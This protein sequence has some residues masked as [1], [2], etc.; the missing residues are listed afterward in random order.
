MGVAVPIA[1]MMDVY[2]TNVAAL[3]NAMIKA[4]NVYNKFKGLPPVDP[5]P[6]NKKT[7]SLNAV[8]EQSKTD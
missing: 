1:A 6:Y 3:T 5:V 8:M 2:N 4:E 7:A